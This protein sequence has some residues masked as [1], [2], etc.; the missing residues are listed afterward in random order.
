MDLAFIRVTPGPFRAFMPPS[1]SIGMDGGTRHQGDALA[2][3][4]Q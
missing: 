4:L 1:L 3:A 2:G